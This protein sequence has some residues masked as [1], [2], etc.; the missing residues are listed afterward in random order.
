LNALSGSFDSAGGSATVLWLVR[1]VVVFGALLS[2]VIS[3]LGLVP[4]SAL[5]GILGHHGE[6][7]SGGTQQLA[8]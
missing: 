8:A 4:P 1:I 3:V 2:A 7:V 5:L 6:P